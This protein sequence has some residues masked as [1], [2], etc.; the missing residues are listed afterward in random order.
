MSSSAYNKR[1]RSR[2]DRLCIKKIW[3]VDWDGRGQDQ[4]LLAKP[5]WLGAMGSTGAC[6]TNSTNRQ[7]WPISVALRGDHRYHQI[8]Q[9]VICINSCK[10]RS[11]ASIFCQRRDS[12]CWEW[13]CRSDLMDFACFSWILSVDKCAVF[14]VFKGIGRNKRY[15]FNGRLQISGA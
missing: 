3:T 6:Q 1:S 4:R 13:A 8:E 11:V 14:W 7:A 12:F 2:Y 9:Y 15:L 5:D 10:N